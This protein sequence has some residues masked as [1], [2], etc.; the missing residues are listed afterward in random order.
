MAKGKKRKRIFKFLLWFLLI[1]I[2][3]T[4]LPVFFYKFVNPP[5]TPLMVLRG[6]ETDKKTDY[7]WVPIEKM[8][9]NLF[10]AALAA[11][12]DT[13]LKHHGFDFR[14]IKLA[15]ESNQKSK[16]TKG[17]STISQQTAKNV[18]LWPHRDFV[19][20][21]LEAWFTVLIE[22]IWGKERIM[23]TYMNVVEF[24]PGVYGVE[25][26]S[27]KYFNKHAAKLSKYEAASLISVLPNPHIYKVLKP[28][29]YTQR[30][31]SA[32]LRR[33]DRIPRVKFD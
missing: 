18:F 28:S 32:I 4:V 23:E 12:D 14:A 1:F 16:R 8:S 2:I 13:F 9:P 27:L 5:I 22:F 3:I 19:R 20:K 26:A 29:A 15:Y 33:M 6:F 17:G 25:A 24:G 10:Q 21:G 30:Y 11:E 7:Q 31:R